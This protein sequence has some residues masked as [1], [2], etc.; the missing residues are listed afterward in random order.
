[1][2]SLAEATMA[3]SSKEEAARS[4]VL[5]TKSDIERQVAVLSPQLERIL[6]NL[7]GEN[8]C[9]EYE[10]IAN[11]VE[12]IDHCTLLLG[13]YDSAV[14]SLRRQLNRVESHNH[15]LRLQLEARSNESQT[16]SLTGIH[17]RRAF[18][19]ELHD[20]C[21]AAQQSHCPLALVFLDI[22]HF[23]SINDSFG[24]HVGDAVLRG[25]AR[26]LKPSL[27]TGTLFARYGGEEFA[28]VFTGLSIDDSLNA[29]ESLRRRVSAT[30]FYYQGQSLRLTISCGLAQLNDSEHCERLMQRADAAMYAAK[31][32]GR[33]RTFWDDSQQLQLAGAAG[34]LDTECSFKSA[35]DLDFPIVD[36]STKGYDNTSNTNHDRRLSHSFSSRT[37][38]ANWC[39]GAT[40]FWNIR[41]RITEWNGGGEPFCVMLMEVDEYAEVAQA[42][43]SMALNFMIRS[44]LL[45]LDAT[46]RDMDIVARFGSC[47]LAVL[48]PRSSLQSL[49]PFLK[50]FREIME[51]FAFPTA[52]GLLNYSV[53][54]GISEV[55]KEDQPQQLL[56]RSELAL[57][58]ACQC[59]KEKFFVNESGESR[60]ICIN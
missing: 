40:L 55:A 43:G 21:V 8:P 1:M 30:Q 46:L 24:H 6:K 48:F 44:Q 54:I 57:S 51:R 28:M 52:N 19:R 53:S 35:A 45:H 39:D 14:D 41:Q 20:R 38:R 10:S 27:P 50:R 13:Q 34:S 26:M 2:E 3:V 36:L 18:D 59:G 56:Q 15:E 9:S 31:Q 42:Y 16:D 32:A 4:M 11:V 60:E 37:N 49:T 33:N 23:K 58:L 17:N 29:I 5:G 22:D 12:Q 7:S 47:R 25:L